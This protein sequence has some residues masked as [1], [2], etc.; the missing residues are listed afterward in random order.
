[1][2][3]MHYDLN[4]LDIRRKLRIYTASGRCVIKEK[5]KEER[6]FICNMCYSEQ[7][8]LLRLQHTFLAF[9]LLLPLA[10]L[11]SSIIA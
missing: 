6:F 9:L 10:V 1:M 2:L 11:V 3:I 8:N 4:I 7:N 5:R